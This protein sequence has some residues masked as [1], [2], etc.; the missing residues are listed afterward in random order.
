MAHAID[1]LSIFAEA[2]GLG[3]QSVVRDLGYCRQ[4][5]VESRRHWA[6]T[7]RRERRARGLCQLCGKSPAAPGTVSRCAD[8]TARRKA[9]KASLRSGGREG[10][11]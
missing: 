8:C 11:K 10:D 7:A 4:D 5:K 6:A 9:V 1:I 2:Q 3:G